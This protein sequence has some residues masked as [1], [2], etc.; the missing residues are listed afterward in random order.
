MRNG[1]GSGLRRCASQNIL[2]RE[3]KRAEEKEEIVVNKFLK[4]GGDV[5]FCNYYNNA[6]KAC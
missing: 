6:A 5:F 3:P 2:N 4:G 1:L